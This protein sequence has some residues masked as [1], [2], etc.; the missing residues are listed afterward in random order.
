VDCAPRTNVPARATATG[1]RSR[2]FVG[3]YE[4]KGSKSVKY[5]DAETKKV[6]TSGNFRLMTFP[7]KDSQVEGIIVFAPDTITREGES[8]AGPGGSTQR[9][10]CGEAR[11]G[12]SADTSNARGSR[13]L[14][15]GAPN[16][17]KRRLEDL[18]VGESAGPAVT[19]VKVPKH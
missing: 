3:Y 9:A 13:S 7:E 17:L 4:T 15:S 2:A 1:K 18:D 12:A 11:D 8:S 10:T 16:R 14:N 19:R 5:Y 6:L